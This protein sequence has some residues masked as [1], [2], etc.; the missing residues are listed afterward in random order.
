MDLAQW[1][2]QYLDVNVY[3]LHYRGLGES[4]GNFKFTQALHEAVEVFDRVNLS[5]P[6]KA[7][8]GHSWGGM[9]GMNVAAQRVGYLSRWL[10]F[11]RLPILIAR[12]AIPLACP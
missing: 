11:P 5:E 2:N 10:C 9:V 3:I 4:H 6:V 8:I 12:S 1:I 7:V